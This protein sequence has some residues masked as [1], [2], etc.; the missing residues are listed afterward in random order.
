MLRVRR[1]QFDAS[2]GNDESALASVRAAA[3]FLGEQS[4]RFPPGFVPSQP[5]Q[6]ALLA[7]EVAPVFE[8][9]DRDAAADSTAVVARVLALHAELAAMKSA[10]QQ[11]RA[12]VSKRRERPRSRKR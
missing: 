11:T 4:A 9:A 5:A 8:G 10:A 2:A 12:A 3:R 7:L 1:W 6:L